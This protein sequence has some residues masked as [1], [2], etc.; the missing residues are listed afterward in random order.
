MTQV[1]RA[2]ALIWK[3]NFMTSLLEHDYDFSILT[4][5]CGI[6]DDNL[7]DSIVNLNSTSNLFRTS[8]PYI[9]SSYSR[10]AFNIFY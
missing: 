6:A 3:T 5:P 1:P 9:A 10:T 2:I 7:T 4:S 8:S